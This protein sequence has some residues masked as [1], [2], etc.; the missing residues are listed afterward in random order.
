MEE[1]LGLQFLPHHLLSRKKKTKEEKEYEITSNILV[2]SLD[3]V[4]SDKSR[5]ENKGR[6]KG[7]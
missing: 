5:T 3:T 4:S 1:G 7:S 6:I 2:G